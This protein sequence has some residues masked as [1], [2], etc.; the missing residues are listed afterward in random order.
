MSDT[1][2]IRVGINGFGRIGRC[3]FKQLME[4]EGVVVVGINDLAEIGDLAYL[5]K[6]DSVHGWYQSKVDHGES[7]LTV[8]GHEVAFFSE[9]DP[10]QIP[11][12]KLN[13]DVV[14]EATG[15]FRSRA[16][17]G[18]HLEAGA[19]KVI[20][21]APSSNADGMFVLGVNDDDYDRAQHHV[22]SNA[23]CTTNCLAPVAKVLDQHF[24]I[25]KLMFT[26]VHAYTASQS[27]MDQPTRKRRR[28]RAAA[29][30]IIP[31]TTGAAEA[32][33]QVLPALAGKVSG[34]AMRVPIPDGSITDISALLRRRTSP[35]EINQVLEQ[36]AAE[37]PL[38]G[39]LRVSDELLV[40]CDILGDPHSSIV[41]ADSTMVLD[42]TMAKVLAWYDNEWGYSARLVDFVHRVV[43]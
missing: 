12:G 9:R 27:L 20:I 19:T 8:D 43:A 40:S 25:E 10:A 23:S 38:A 17:A 5:L 13:A 30:S 3:T 14:I 16:D 33:E 26:T 11:W 39:I 15:L 36:A 41:D 32:T 28:G 37:G 4:D 24:G 6:Y 22:I 42:G 2:P 29:L 35:G 31:T 21:S 1:P 34:M 7:T 18:K